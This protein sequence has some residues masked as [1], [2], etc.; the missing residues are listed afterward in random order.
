M[1]C[2]YFVGSVSLTASGGRT[3]VPA[4]ANFIRGTGE[5]T[6]AVALLGASGATTV[7]ASCMTVFGGASGETSVNLQQKMNRFDLVAWDPNLIDSSP[8]VRRGTAFKLRIRAVDSV[9]D[10][11]AYTGAVT[12]TAAGGTI[13]P[14]SVTFI[15]GWLGETTMNVTLSG[16]SAIGR[17]TITA[18]SG[19]FTGR[20]VVV[21]LADNRFVINEVLPADVNTATNDDRDEWVE[22]RNRSTGALSTNGWILTDYDGSDINLPD[23]SIP[24]GKFLV[25]HFREPGTTDATFT[26]T[27]GAAHFFPYSTTS[28][29]L[30]YHQEEAGLYSSTTKDSRTVASYV[31]WANAASWNAGQMEDDAVGAA[32]WVNDAVINHGAASANALAG[33]SLFRIVDGCDSERS[34]SDWALRAASDTYTFTEGFANT[35]FDSDLTGVSITLRSY[36][37]STDTVAVGETLVVI[38]TATGGGNPA[39]IGVT[40]V[41]L[42]SNTDSQGIVLTLVESTSGSRTYIQ[43]A[44]IVMHSDSGS[45]DG[46]RWLGTSLTDTVT[47]T[48]VRGGADAIAA[49]PAP[50]N[51][52]GL[53]A[54]SAISNGYAFSLTITARTATGLTKVDYTGT[55]NLTST[56]GAISPTSVTFAASDSGSKT[57]AVMITGATAG[58]TDTITAT[59]ATTGETG[60]V[61]IDVVAA[62]NVVINEIQPAPQSVDWD[63]SGVINDNGNDEWYE[64]FNRSSETVGLA[65]WRLGR[66]DATGILLSDSI[67]PRG[68]ITVYRRTGGPPWGLGYIFDSAGVFIKTV[69]YGG[70]SPL[71]AV[72]TGG[73]FVLKNAAGIVID[74]VTYPSMNSNRDSSYQRAWDGANLFRIGRPSPGETP[75]AAPWNDTSPNIR[76]RLNRPDTAS[77]NETVTLIIVAVDAAGETV[78]DFTASG[79]A[80]TASGGPTLSISTL[81]FTSG[82]CS[83]AVKFLTATGT[84]TLTIRHET[85]SWGRGAVLVVSST[86]EV[87]LSKSLYAVTLGGAASPPIPGASIWYQL[88]YNN[89]GPANAD[90]TIIRDSIALTTTLCSAS[91][92]SETLG[93]SA[94][95]ND[96]FP[97]SGWQ[98]QYSTSASPDQADTSAD[99]VAGWPTPAVLPNVRWI[100]WR[101]SSVPNGQTATIRFRVILR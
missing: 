70:N 49:V 35:L 18:T 28:N 51:N 58:A 16:D 74:T 30:S 97:A 87:T 60:R 23:I 46:S 88:T 22:I 69:S 37:G 6:I 63:R 77:L 100:R 61:V 85:N 89:L 56:P 1:R 64:I 47:A 27:D 4:V 59:E 17:D 71:E 20:T 92:Q 24:S 79:V 15:S 73:V 75:A 41:I 36:G 96:S 21:P 54:P 3:I 65:S 11:M 78:T 39:V 8:T 62:A 80:V 32:L 45:R 10:T 31:S 95:F 13:S 9:G 40:T 91:R 34:P 48:W 2:S 43:E 90:T 84:A 82:I 38:L 33:R 66:T 76:F 86:A 99:Y 93:A 44:L 5:T 50:L 12:L 14:P 55:V 26:D 29:R 98:F 52:F 83:T 72:N 94:T 19:S 67:P 7:A 25:V 81:T 101:R 53:S 57:V 68:Y 42:K